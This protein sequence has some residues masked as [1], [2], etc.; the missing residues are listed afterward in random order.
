[1]LR[2]GENWFVLHATI[3]CIDRNIKSE[4]TD[5]NE[6][7]IFW[8]T[9]ESTEP[10][11]DIGTEHIEFLNCDQSID[12]MSNVDS[13]HG[14]NSFDDSESEES[15]AENTAT[16]IKCEAID[17]NSADNNGPKKTVT[18]KLPK[19][20]PD[21]RSKVKKT[22]KGKH[23]KPADKVYSCDICVRTFARSDYLTSHNLHV[24]S[25]AADKKFKCDRCDASFVKNSELERHKRQNVACEKCGEGYCLKPLLQAHQKYCIP[26]KFEEN[27]SANEDMAKRFNISEFNRF[28]CDICKKVFAMKCRVKNHILQVHCESSRTVKCELCNYSCFSKAILKTHHRNRHS[29]KEKNF[30]C[31]ECGKAFHAQYLL[32]LHGYT[33]TGYKPYECSYEGCSRR[34]GGQ[35][36]RLVHMRSHTGE[37]PYICDVD[38]C[39]RRFGHLGGLKRHK[40]RTHGIYTRKYTCNVCSFEFPES[41][42]LKRH[43]KTHGTL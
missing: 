22:K 30:V 14:F 37:K 5:E 15:G 39:R 24:H 40:F 29:E 9:I 10:N 2:I 7:H 18:K 19:K 20:R 3:Q 13:E 28:E 1:M 11:P 23:K 35:S 6:S 41:N 31:S 42:L 38:E 32:R 36:Q 16:D 21:K 34:F 8:Q 4:P 25:S 27:L 12:Q 43:L 26:N 33:H 17:E